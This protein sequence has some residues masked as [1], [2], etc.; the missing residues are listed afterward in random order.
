MNVTDSVQAVMK[1]LNSDNS[2]LGGEEFCLQK[3]REKLIIRHFERCDKD[4]IVLC[5][6]L[7]VTGANHQ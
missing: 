4:H 3:S 5:L 6:L 1:W 7:M 2:A